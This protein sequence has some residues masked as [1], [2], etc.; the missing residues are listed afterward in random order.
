MSEE[1]YEQMAI[2][3]I[4]NYLNKNFDDEDIKD[5]YS[6]AIKKVISNI[7]ELEDIPEGIAVTKSG[8][9]SVTYLNKNIMTKDVKGLLPMP[10]IKLF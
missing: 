9:D 6:F 5:K 10:F 2:I 1:E 7:K 3:Y 4:K 8:E